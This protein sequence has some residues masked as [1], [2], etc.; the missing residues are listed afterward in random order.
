[1]SEPFGG[2][3]LILVGN[4]QQLPPVS[5]KTLYELG[6]GAYLLFDAIE[7]VVQIVEPQQK[8]CDNP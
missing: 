2:L 1:M 4:F 8:L 3:C 7:N 5:D 6:Y